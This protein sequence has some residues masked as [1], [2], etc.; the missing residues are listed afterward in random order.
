MTDLIDQVVVVGEIDPVVVGPKISYSFRR[1]EYA[2]RHAP[3]SRGVPRS[4]RARTPCCRDAPR[5]GRPSDW[6]GAFPAS[7]GTLGQGLRVRTGSSSEIREHRWQESITPA[8]GVR[9]ELRNSRPPMRTC[10]SFPPASCGYRM[11][12]A[13]VPPPLGFSLELQDRRSFSQTRALPKFGMSR[14]RAPRTR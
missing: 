5:Q 10:V 2:K 7:P 14:W 13:G 11:S 6:A 8:A 3:K 1:K 12:S 9:S 4:R